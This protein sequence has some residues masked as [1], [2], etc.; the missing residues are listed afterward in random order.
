MAEDKEQ[1]QKTEEPTQKRI[2]DAIKQGNVAFSREV[3]AFL[4]LM[5]ATLLVFWISGG[6]SFIIV[7]KLSIYLTDFSIFTDHDGD[8]NFPQVFKHAIF[9]FILFLAGL[10]VFSL[11]NAFLG[12]FMQ[13]GIIYSPEAL[14]PKLE[15]ISPLSGL[16]RMFSKKSIVEFLKGLIKISILGFIC[17]MVLKSEVNT[18]IM[19]VNLEAVHIFPLFKSLLEKALIAVCIFMAFFAALD[20]LYTKF[21][22]M[23]S[24]RMTKEEVKEE[25]KQSEGS[26]EIKAKIRSLRQ[27]RLRKMSLA[28]VKDA[29][30]IITNPTHYSIALKY[31]KEI[32]PAPQ[33]V[34]KGV[35][36]MALQIRK[37]AQKHNIPLMENRPLARALYEN[38]EVDDFIPFEHYKAV[39]DIISK[40]MK[41]K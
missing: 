23:Q 25:M 33:V 21:E 24:L 35:D 37:I 11:L 2:D 17:Y 10:F 16:K 41:N 29:D 20:Y 34:A 12:S 1:S 30:V 22:Y 7:K 27:S 28:A 19:S 32:M 8:I 4:S 13:N 15:R 36:N 5:F 9:G 39:A 18:A 3:N 31:K 38:V 6:A 26:P 40:I 14:E